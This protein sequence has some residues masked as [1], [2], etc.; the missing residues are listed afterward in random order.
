MATLKKEDLYSTLE[1][2]QER[3]KSYYDIDPCDH[4]I[5]RENIESFT[6]YVFEYIKD[7]FAKIKAE[8]QSTYSQERIYEFV[9]KLK[10]NRDYIEQRYGSEDV[11]DD[12]KKIHDLTQLIQIFFE[13][14]IYN[15][16]EDCYYLLFDDYP[17][18]QK[19]AKNYLKHYSTIIAHLIFQQ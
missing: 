16:N 12:A 18:I 2:A 10:H 3:L 6:S 1:R 9:E 15:L 4:R 5:L 14:D 17:E 7:D 11:V 19:W 13:N 8:I